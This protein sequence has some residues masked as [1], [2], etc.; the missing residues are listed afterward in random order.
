[1]VSTGPLDLRTQVD[2]DLAGVPRGDELTTAA[3]TLLQR[4]NLRSQPPTYAPQQASGE[5]LALRWGDLQQRHPEWRGDYWAEC[6]A[7]YAGGERLLADPEVMKRL[8][9]QHLYEDAQVY[10]ARQQ[11]AHYF[12]YPGTII[13]HMLAGLGTDPLTVSFHDVDDDGT[14]EDMPPEAEWWA[15]WVS[16]VTDEAEQPSDYGLAPKTDSDSDEDDDEGGKPLHD[17]LVEVLRESLQ[18]RCAWVLADLPQADPDAVIDSQLAAEQSGLNDPYLCIVPA[19]QV[20]DWR[21]DERGRLEWV[22]MLV[23]TQPRATPRDRRGN[24]LHT[25]TLWTRDIWAR[26]DVPVDPRQPPHESVEFKPAEMGE[27]GFGRVP[28]ER[29]ELPDGLYAMGKLHSLAREHFNKRCAMGWAEY[30]ALFSIL[31]EFMGGAEEDLPTAGPAGDPDRATNQIR[32]QGYTQQRQAKDRAEYVGPG[33]D[34][35]VAARESCNDAMR[36]MHRVMFSMALSANMDSKALNR[37]AES[38]GKDE[39]STSILLDAFGKMLIKFARRLL[40]LASLGRQE[41]VPHA[42]ISGLEDFD[43][44][45]VTAAINEAVAFFA[46]IPQHSMLVK[47]LALAKVYSAY[48]SGLTPEQTEVMRQQIRDGLS[49]EEMQ[50][51]QLAGMGAQGGVG[52]DGQAPKG[53]PGAPGRPDN[54][55][56]GP[57][58]AKPPGT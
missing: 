3:A 26:Y 13:D 46:G 45:S 21:C 28:F 27:H 54:P 23:I 22:L 8:F 40:V 50:A 38:K 57:P 30:K 5:T 18:T 4:N 37:S 43:V 39:A 10:K 20:I 19:E 51:Q 34:A 7:L 35:F 53:E 24:L 29:L 6:R 11:R 33:S 42:E 16:D 55:A 32:G 47:E 56:P 15:E 14:V 44:E 41:A 12:P 2:R 58:K 31:Y 1:M 17:F 9:P 49:M 48:L 25:Y 52:P 36:E